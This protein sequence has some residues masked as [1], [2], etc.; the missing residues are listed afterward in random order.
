LPEALFSALDGR[1]A[2]AAGLASSAWLAE[3]RYDDGARGHLLAIVGAAPGAERT[4]AQA[5]G[6]ALGFS[7]LEAGAL[8]VTF[9]AAD[10][11]LLDRIARTGLRFDIS[12]PEPAVSASGPAAPG[13]DPD[14]PPRLK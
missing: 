10:S 9:V 1:L 7:G 3:V 5:V 4:L 12:A 6:E 2:R 11:P 13:M 14:R 8:D